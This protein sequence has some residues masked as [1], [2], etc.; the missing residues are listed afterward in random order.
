MLNHNIEV[1]VKKATCWK[2][3]EWD[4]NARCREG[5]LLEPKNR[6]QAIEYD[7]AFIFLSLYN[8]EFKTDYEIMELSDIPDIKCKDRLTN[9]ELYLEITLHEDAKGEIPLLLGRTK[10]KPKA[11]ATKRTV[12]NDEDESLVILIEAINKKL[13]KNYGRNVA[14]VV[15]H[16]SSKSWNLHVEQI[17]NSLDL[18]S[19]PFDKG[20][21][22]LTSDFRIIS[23]G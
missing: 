18:K 12:R 4:E 10:E 8:K 6:K 1:T 9:A 16:M 22:I 11:Q 17:K 5:D 23:I 15:R 3:L 13:L 2:K 7:S 20:I 19:N 14:L 21:W